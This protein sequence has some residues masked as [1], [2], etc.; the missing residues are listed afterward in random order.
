MNSEIVDRRIYRFKGYW[1]Q[2]NN[3]KLVVF[4]YF[5]QD[6]FPTFTQSF[7]NGIEQLKITYKI[8]VY[9]N[10]HFTKGDIVILNK[11][12]FDEVELKVYN[13]KP[14]FYEPN[15]LIADLVKQRVESTELLLQ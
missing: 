14:K 3:D 9:G 7:E 6:G 12:S 5:M 11:D 15:V 8:Q 4:F 13:T 1:K 2:V 10:L